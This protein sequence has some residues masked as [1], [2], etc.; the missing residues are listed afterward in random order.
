[1]K[2]GAKKAK[3]LLKKVVIV[4]VGYLLLKKPEKDK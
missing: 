4:A 3:K 1:M 2:K